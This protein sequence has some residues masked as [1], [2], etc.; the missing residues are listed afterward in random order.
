[1]AMTTDVRR[2][3]LAE[4]RGTV[5]GQWRAMRDGNAGIPGNHGNVHPLR[6]PHLQRS[7]SMPLPI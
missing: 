5:S 1:M 6:Q 3:R 7:G 2:R 4:D